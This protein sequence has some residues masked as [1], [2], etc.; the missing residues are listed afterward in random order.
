MAKQCGFDVIELH[1][2]HGYLL[3]QFISPTTNC[4]KDKYGGSIENRI[5]FPLEVLHE[6]RGAVKILLLSKDILKEESPYFLIWS[7]K[8]I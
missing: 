3:S 4:R 2:G 8:H 7:N 1:L 5:R 6:V